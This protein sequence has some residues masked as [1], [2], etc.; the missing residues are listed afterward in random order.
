MLPQAYLENGEPEKA[1]A[2]FSR[3]QGQEMEDLQ[4]VEL[5][6]LELIRLHRTPPQWEVHPSAPLY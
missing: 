6:T 4:Q 2:L 5:C 3:I 1:Y